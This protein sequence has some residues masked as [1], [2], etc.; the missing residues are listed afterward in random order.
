V[1]DP[2]FC[3]RCGRPVTVEAGRFEVFERMHY[4]CFHYEFEHDPFDPD[5]ECSAGGCPSAAI[6]QTRRVGRRLAR[7]A[8]AGLAIGDALRSHHRLLVS[9]ASP[10]AGG[11]ILESAADVTPRQGAAMR[12]TDARA[13][14]DSFLAAAGVDLGDLA[15][16]D[17]VALMLEWYSVERADD[18]DLSD[19]GDMLLYQWGTYDW[20]NGP[21]FQLDITRQLIAVAG[22]DDD[23]IWQLSVTL[24]FEPTDAAQAVGAAD[25]WCGHPDELEEMRRFINESK[26]MHLYAS[27]RARKVEVAYDVAG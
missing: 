7:E 5:E 20:G 19:G 27:R 24:H 23:D 12:V 2:L 3:L 9:G 18:A 13:A 16:A 14:F 11:T 25:R 22:S 1:A 6:G 8:I 10:A 4:V 17:A 26:P 15:A 21:S